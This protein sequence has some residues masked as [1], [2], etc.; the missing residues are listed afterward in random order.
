MRQIIRRQTKKY[1]FFRKKFVLEFGKKMD[2]QKYEPMP[3]KFDPNKNEFKSLFYYY[4]P[5]L[6]DVEVRCV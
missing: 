5:S 3:W 6:V 2:Q 4:N 1:F